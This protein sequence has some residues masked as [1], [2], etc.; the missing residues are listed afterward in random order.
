MGKAKKM[1]ETN[2]KL[3]CQVNCEG[4]KVLKS[5]CKFDEN[6]AIMKSRLTRKIC[7]VFDNNLG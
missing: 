5:C 4:E 6:M 7:N 2:F 1:V 3:S